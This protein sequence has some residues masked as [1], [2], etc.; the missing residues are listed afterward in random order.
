MGKVSAIVIHNTFPLKYLKR[1]FIFLIALM[2]L[3]GSL[4]AGSIRQFGLQPALAIGGNTGNF[5]HSSV[6]DFINA[7]TVQ[8]DVRPVPLLSGTVLGNLNGGEVRL[9]A[10]LEDHF[11]GSSV[12]PALWLTGSVYDWYQVPPSVSGGALN[13]DSAYLR[14][15]ENFQPYANRFF[16]ARA[17]VA[18]DPPGVRGWPDLGFYRALPPLDEGSVTADSAIRLFVFPESGAT[19]VRGR[20]GDDTN[21]LIDI[22]IPDVNW[23]EYHT[24]RIEWDQ[25]QSRFYVDDEYQAAISGTTDLNTYVFLYHQDPITT[26]TG[27]GLL[28]VDWVRAGQYP[29]SGSYT[30]CVQDAGGMVN[31]STMNV[32]ST[33]PSGSSLVVETRT[34]ADTAGA[35]WSDWTALNGNQVISPSGRYFQYRLMYTSNQVTSPEVQSVTVNY[36][37]PVSLALSPASVTLDPGE[38]QQFVVTASDVNGRPL[39]GLV[40]SWSIVNSGGTITQNGLF[41]AGLAPAT[42][43]N[44]VRVATGLVGGGTLTQS[45]TVT[46]RDLPTTVDAG[47]PYYGNEGSVIYLAATGSDPNGGGEV[48][49]YAWDLD[50][51][52]TY[53]ILGQTAE[54]TYLDN[55][56][57]T[58]GVRALDSALNPVFDAALVEFINV[59]PTITNISAGSPIPEGSS[60]LITVTASDP[61]GEN[62]PLLY[63]F[64][65]TNNGSFE[66]ESQASNSANCT[67]G[68]NGTYTVRVRVTD[69]DGGED[70]ETA[71]VIVNSVAPTITNV[72]AN[73]N[74]VSEGSPSNISVTAT[75]PAGANDPLQ[76][77]F[78]CDGDTI[79][80]IGPQSTSSTNCLFGDNGSYTVRVRVTDGDGEA[81]TSTTGVTVINVPPVIT[82]TYNN[83]P[84]DEGGNATITI[85]ASDAASVNDPLSYEFDCDNDGEYEIGSQESPNALCS[86]VNDG[87]FT[88]GVRV[89]DGDGGVDTDSTAVSVLNVAPTILSVVNNGPKAPNQPVLI[90]I[91]AS[92]PGVNDVLTYE[93]D[94]NNDGGFELTG[95]SNQAVCSYA[96]EDSYTVAVRVMDD[97]EPSVTSYTN[98]DILQWL[99]HIPIVTLP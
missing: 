66:I 10:T 42:Y 27:R 47:G 51:D 76:Y 94:C 96:Y 64:D 86:F 23:T 8:T 50:G 22:N 44:T 46:V 95:S 3:G 24:Y 36:Y 30:S 15:Q 29:A 65:C 5:T 89:A 26:G 52:G 60:A 87:N 70:I 16:E 41:T 63:S 62:D 49:D 2:L 45:A 6:S 98:F 43:S 88:V 84:V 79:Y 75:D 97:D 74:P 20:D 92:D 54:I 12:N 1:L 71:T 57:F 33:I 83:G 73:P 53:E 68:D 31:F 34:Q 21:P 91:T 93:F 56:F 32:T 39:T 82:S 58:V 40:Y 85:T 25:T 55:A 4:F 61:A 59:P 90:T 80:E 35:Q 37:G 18:V 14:S 99:V 67:Y 72:T 78:S 69:G 77:S 38:Q 13:L 28:R 19:F 48:T 11:N 7:C 17:I 81:T 9:A